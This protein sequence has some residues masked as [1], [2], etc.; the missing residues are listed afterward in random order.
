MLFNS[1]FVLLNM[2]ACLTHFLLNKVWFS[3]SADALLLVSI[4]SQIRP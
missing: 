3:S 4:I 2:F 1:L